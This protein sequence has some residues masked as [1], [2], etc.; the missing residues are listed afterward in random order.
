MWVGEA[1]SKRRQLASVK[2][3]DFMISS[4]HPLASKAG[5]EIM[6]KNGNVIDAII[7]AQMV[8]NA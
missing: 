2:S 7:A 4:A 1:A 8:L 5:Y 3:S 6:A